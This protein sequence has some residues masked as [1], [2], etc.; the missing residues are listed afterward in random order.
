MEDKN[1]WID[2]TKMPADTVVDCEINGKVFALFY[3]FDKG[4]KDAIF[5]ASSESSVTREWSNCNIFAKKIRISAKNQWLPWFGGECPV[6]HNC[7]V[8][9]WMRGK[10]KPSREHQAGE[11][12]WDHLSNILDN[13]ANNSSDII[14]YR[15]LESPWQTISGVCDET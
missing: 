6:P 8:E 15:L 3:V 1:G 14:A 2:F 11:L 5:M 7:M 9:Y 10:A 13:C 4:P 12:R